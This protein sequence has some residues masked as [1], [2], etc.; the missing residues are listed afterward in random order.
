VPA[1]DARGATARDKAVPLHSIGQVL[2]LLRPEFTDLTISKLRFLESE[3]LVEPL[4]TP[5]GYRKY[6]AA[7]VQRLRLILT[8]QRERHLPLR[9]IREQLAAQERAG[10]PLV[11][12]AR[13]GSVPETH[14]TREQL[15]ERSGLGEAAL[16]DLERFGLL[17][18]GPGGQ[19]GPEALA[20]ARIAARLADFGIEGRHLRPYRA[21]ADREVGLLAQLVAPLSK[22]G[23]R[24]G[25]AAALET[26]Q[27]LAALCAQLHGALVRT[28]LRAVVE[29]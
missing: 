11:L 7:H 19:Y 15:R 12:P 27:E 16:A 4:R 25:R 14:L 29:G 13:A 1:D 3:G 24:D 23:G 26:V 21:A 20:V 18:A 9:V 17:V 2:K 5:A 28:G 10:I 8:A 22:Q 6:T